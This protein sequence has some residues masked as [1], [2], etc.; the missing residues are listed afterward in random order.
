MPVLLDAVSIMSVEAIQCAD[1]NEPRSIPDNVRAD[2]VCCQPTDTL[3]LVDGEQFV[4]RMAP[5][6]AVQILEPGEAY[7]G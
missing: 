3:E 2:L 6:V 7:V 5:H 4:L 1:P